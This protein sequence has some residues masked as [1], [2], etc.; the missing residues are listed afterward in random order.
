H[1]VTETQRLSRRL[2]PFLSI[3]RP[4]FF[5]NSEQSN[6]LFNS[7]KIVSEVNGASES[8]RLRVS[9]S[10]SLRVSASP[11]LRVSVSPYP[12]SPCLRVSLSP[13]L[14]VPAS[15]CLRGERVFVTPS[16]V[17]SASAHH[18]GKMINLPALSTTPAAAGLTPWALPFAPM[19]LF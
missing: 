12:L 3:H 18:H 4:N 5:L 8:P 2:M 17:N 19:G 14:R 16:E 13:G 6:P 1:G 9:V 15:P 10:P 11:C 7:Q